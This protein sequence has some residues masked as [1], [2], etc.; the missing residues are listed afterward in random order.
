MEDQ[1]KAIGRMAAEIAAL[2]R[3]AAARSSHEVRL[4]ELKAKRD[5]GQG[6]LGSLKS[7]AR[8]P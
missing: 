4:G 6:E 7:R 3:E 8:H 1:A 5:G 2:E